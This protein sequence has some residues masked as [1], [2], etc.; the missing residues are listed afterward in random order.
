MGM[1]FVFAAG[2]ATV[3]LP[4]AL[5]AV[6]LRRLFIGGHTYLYVGGGLVVLALAAYTL[7]GEEL[8]LPM[9]GRAPGRRA[10]SWGVYTLRTFSGVASSCCAPVLA[11]VV[12]LAGVGGSLAAGAGLGLAYVFGMVAPLFVLALAWDRWGERAARLFKPRIFTWRIGPI[13]R[14]ISGSGLASGVLLTLM[15]GG[16]VRVGLAGEAMPTSSGWQA[17]FTVALQRAGRTVTDAFAWLPG[18]AAALGLIAIVAGL[19]RLAWHQTRAHLDDTVD[20][21]TCSALA[22]DKTGTEEN[23]AHIDA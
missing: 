16:M 11:G 12:A 17:N 13:R 9:P 14:S 6:A 5:G 8:R 15:G 4:L 19:A 10:G 20:A 2:V 22:E 1:T 21:P 23:H 7:S 3:I 18:W